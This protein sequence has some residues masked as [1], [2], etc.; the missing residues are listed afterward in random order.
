MTIRAAP[1]SPDAHG[2]SASIKNAIVIGGCVL[3]WI[4]HLFIG[5]TAHQQ[6]R[7]SGFDLSVFDYAIW[8]TGTGGP[9][10][11]VPMFGYSLLAQHFMPAVLLLAPLGALFDTPVYLIALQSTLFVAGAYLLYRVAVL[12]VPGPYA[13]ALLVAYL[14]SRR[15]HSAATSYFYIESAEPLLVF[16]ALLAW[17]AGLRVWYWVLLIL[18][19]GCK[20]DVA[21]YFGLFGVMQ[22]VTNH[23]GPART[24][25]W[26][27]AAV[28]AVWAAVALFIAVPYW[29]EAYGLGSA[30]PILS[31]RYGIDDGAG[32]QAALGRMFSG[33]ALSKLVT[34]TSMVGFLCFLSPRW[35]AIVLPGIA[36]NLA[37]LP[38][39][40]Q[41]GLG[42]HYLWPILPWLF[43][44]AV[45]GAERLGSHGLR[46]IPWVVMLIGVA[47]TP[48]PSAIVK[49]V[50]RDPAASTVSTQLQSLDLS[51]TVVAQPNLI[52]HLPR[53]NRVFGY[54]VY[55]EGQPEPDLVLLTKTGDLWPLGS[56][57]AEGIDRELARWRADARFEQVS[58]GPLWA[59]RR[60][61]R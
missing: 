15:S 54:G 47:D 20:E 42:G 43:V 30:N 38:G 40:N 34:V 60:S 53:H 27:T 39:T 55:S 32:V 5:I 26:L 24:L 11:F 48:L 6:L 52:P 29:S 56:N 36:F 13:L 45:H 14:L 8:N 33:A 25:G 58:A 49:S 7:T 3:A 10:A 44:A 28:C 22:A 51:S 37:A 57:G 35:L 61:I 59:F 17:S 4:A 23:P 21:L 2:A 12:R 19:L 50:H 9:I 1:I 31:G 46:W 41:A 18:A 16:G